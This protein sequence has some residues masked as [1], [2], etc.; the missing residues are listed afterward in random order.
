[1]KKRKILIPMPKSKFILVKC[2]DCENEQVIFNHATTEV[3]CLICG[4]TLA[5]PSGGKAIIKTKI[6]RVLE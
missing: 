4:R 6:V 2:P 1:M 5:R 3:K